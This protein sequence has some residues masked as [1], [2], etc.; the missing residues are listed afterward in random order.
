MSPIDD[1]QRR[2]GRKRLCGVAALQHRTSLRA[3]PRATQWHKIVVCDISRGGIRFLHSEQ[4]FPDEQMLLVLP[5]FKRRFVEIT[6]C[7]CL[8]DHYFEIGAG[9]VK[10]LRL[11]PSGE[12]PAAADV[13]GCTEPVGA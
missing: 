2:F 4:I 10:L 11:S 5:D 12:E 3:L 1:D 6:R 9:F 7:R 8:G 13:P